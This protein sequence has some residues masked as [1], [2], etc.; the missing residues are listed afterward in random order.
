MKTYSVN[1]IDDVI[2]ENFRLEVWKYIR[3]QKY[4]ATRKNLGYPHG[5]IVYYTP[6]DNQKEYM[7]EKLPMVN[8]QYMHRCIFG[9]N[10]KELENHPIILKLWN[11]INTYLENKFIIDGDEEGVADDGNGN[12]GFSRVYVNAQPEETIK[13][14]H[15]I[16]RDTIDLNETKNYTLLYIANPEW[17]PT[18][19]AENIF[20]SDDDSTGD[21]QQYQKGYGQSRNF[22]VGWPFFTVSPKPGRIILYDGRTL[23]T[24]KPAAVWAKEHRYAIAFRIK[25]IYD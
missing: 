3:N 4:H 19:M 2:P 5:D 1:V 22:N 10:E 25:K 24:T 15:A 6:K 12:P 7:S 18:W 23:H 14:S 8:N 17:Y 9:D 16:H 20:Y 21:N 13:R 11:T